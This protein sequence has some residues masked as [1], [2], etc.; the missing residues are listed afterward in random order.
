MDQH[1]PLAEQQR[2]EI[3]LH[4][5]ILDTPPEA[6]FDRIVSI[7]TAVFGTSIAMIT[8]V[9]RDR[10]WYKSEVGFGVSEAPRSDNMCDAVLRHDDVLVISDSLLAT[11]E[12]VAPMLKKGVRFYAGAPLRSRDGICIGT[13]CTIDPLP[14]DVTPEQR[15][16][17]SNLAETVMD[18]LELR[19]TAR[20]FAETEAELRRLNVE[21]ERASRNK[22]EFL[23]SMS[24]ELRTPLN[25]VLGASE[26]LGQG[27]FGPLN[28]KQQEYIEDIHQSGEHLLRLIDDVLDLVRIEAGQKQ[29]DSQPLDVAH[30]MDRCIALVRGSATAKSQELIVLPPDEALTMVADERSVT[31]VACN[32]LSNALKF[33]PAHGR[34]LF[35]AWQDGKQ[36]TF[37]VDDQGPGIAAEFHDRIFDQFFRIAS[38]QE[39]TGLGLPLARQLIE[40]QG[41]SISLESAEGFGSRFYFSLPVSAD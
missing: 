8:L 26:L 3:L 23:A 14:K 22:S 10:S 17:L 27:L 38:D 36:V 24:H 13:V 35:K 9:D 37:V 25:G 16:I 29:F 41:G 33:T 20:K 21:L 4:Y 11:P 34:I 19:L 15:M 31:Q 18:E 32:L 5:E 1:S 40:G 28:P 6:S 39:G 30:F 7:I 2:Q 12:Q